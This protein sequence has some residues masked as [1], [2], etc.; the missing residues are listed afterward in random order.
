MQLWLSWEQHKYMNVVPSDQEN[1]LVSGHC[2]HQFLHQQN[3]SKCCM[4]LQNDHCS[5]MLF[6]NNTRS[7]D[8]VFSKLVCTVHEDSYV[9]L[10]IFGM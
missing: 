1:N 5:I 2:Q 10:A 6:T 9:I 8:L 4:H 7:L 3:I